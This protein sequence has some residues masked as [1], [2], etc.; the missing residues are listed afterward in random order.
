M[1][2]LYGYIR[3]SCRLI[4]SE[5]GNDPD[6]QRRQLMDAGVPTTTLYQDLGVSGSTGTNTRQGWRSL[7]S[8]LHQGAFWWSPQSTASAGAGLT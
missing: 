1:A 6:T 5:A 3:T 2:T 4:A 8:H 7:T